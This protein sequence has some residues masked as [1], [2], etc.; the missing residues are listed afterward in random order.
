M[1]FTILT[2]IS[3]TGTST[4]TPTTVAKAAGEVV[5]NN[6]IATDKIRVS[7]GTFTLLIP[8]KNFTIG[9]KATKMIKSF[10]AT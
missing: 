3:I 2:K 7:H 6:A 1:L 9:T 10:V 8:N 5:P 4:S